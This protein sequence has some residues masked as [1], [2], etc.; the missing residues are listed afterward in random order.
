MS[1]KPPLGLALVG[2]TADSAS[3]VSRP[4]KCGEQDL[5]F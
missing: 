1:E 3:R 2:I 4:D 5:V